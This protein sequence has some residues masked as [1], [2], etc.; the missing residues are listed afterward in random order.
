MAASSARP[1]SPGSPRPPTS[2]ADPTSWRQLTTQAALWTDEGSPFPQGVWA[3]S[4]RAKGQLINTNKLF[5]TWKPGNVTS[6]VNL[7]QKHRP[8]GGV[9]VS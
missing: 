7:G 3:G 1:P 4:P 5:G 2:I 9:R 8:Q 6:N